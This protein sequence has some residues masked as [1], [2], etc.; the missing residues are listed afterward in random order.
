MAMGE[1]ATTSPTVASKDLTKEFKPSDWPNGARMLIVLPDKDIFKPRKPAIIECAEACA[2]RGVTW[3]A[4]YHKD[5]TPENLTYL[6]NKSGVRYIYWC[7]HANSHVGKNARLQ[8]EGVQRTNTV[9]WKHTERNWWFDKWEEIR[10]FSYINSQE[11]LPDDWDNRGFS[12]W[13]LGMHDS[14]N[15]KIIFVDG[16]L[17][18][19]YADM[20][21]AYGVFSLQG[22]GSLD[23]IYIGWRKEVL[24]STGLME[25]IVG[26]TTEGVR[27]FWE[28]MG[29]G[30]TIWNA[31]YETELS[32]GLGMRQA[33]WGLNGTRDIGVIN[34]DDN[35]FLYGNGIIT[36][37]KLDP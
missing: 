20:A 3:L 22:Q 4:L 34:G 24:V 16:C 14:W 18:A 32:G 2:A 29:R 5:V 23:Q 21:R 6:Y 12:L 27:M 30:R 31:L 19:E 15:K 17:S 10:V 28:E 37:M 1:S 26:N 9:C 25:R 35:L 13:S 36:S 8:V 33:L 7:G 11:P